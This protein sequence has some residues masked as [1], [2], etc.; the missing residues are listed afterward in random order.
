MAHFVCYVRWVERT[1]WRTAREGNGAGPFG[2]VLRTAAPAA[3]TKDYPCWQ[4]EISGPGHVFW[5]VRPSAL[6]N[7]RVSA[8]DLRCETIIS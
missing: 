3:G 6:R 7:L 5:G 2:D 4:L 8:P 1:H